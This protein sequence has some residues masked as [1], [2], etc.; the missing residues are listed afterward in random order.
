VVS[1]YR[2]LGMEYSGGERVCRSL[3]LLKPEG[4]KSIIDIDLEGGHAS[5]DHGDMEVSCERRKRV[6]TDS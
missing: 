1:R 4:M 2:T 3:K 5:I 6:M